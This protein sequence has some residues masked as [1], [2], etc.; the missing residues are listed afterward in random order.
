MGT[1]ITIDVKGIGY[2]YLENSWQVNFDNKYDG[3]LSSITTHGSAHATIT[4]AGTPGLH[5]LQVLHGWSF[6]PYLN[7]AQS[8]RPDREM[9]TLN[10]R[11]TDGPAVMPPPL[12]QQQLRRV[13]GHLGQHRHHRGIEH[14]M[15]QR[16]PGQQF[17]C[18]HGGQQ[19]LEGH[20]PQLRRR[21]FER[22]AAGGAGHL[23]A[24]GQQCRGRLGWGLRGHAVSGAGEGNR[25][26]V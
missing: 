5:V 13:V 25:T 17:A 10:F 4:A 2:Q 6:V 12:E 14:R 16:R 8:P 7:N 24:D 26:L 22:A 19:H 11:I 20:V 23:D 21:L 18:R 3:W 1:P 9:F 15:R